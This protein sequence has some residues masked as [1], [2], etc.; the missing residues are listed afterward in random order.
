MGVFRGQQLRVV[1]DK[2]LLEQDI[3]SCVTDKIKCSW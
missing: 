3:Q 2:Y 1:R